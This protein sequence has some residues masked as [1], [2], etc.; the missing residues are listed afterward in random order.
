MLLTL[1]TNEEKNF[2]GFKANYSQ[3]PLTQ[4][5]TFSSGFAF[6]NKVKG[7][8]HVFMMNERMLSTMVSN[9]SSPL[10]QTVEVLSLETKASYPHPS[11]LPIILHKPPVCG[12]SR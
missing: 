4:P 7:R 3:I 5:G 10:V 9:T 1:L 8:Q 11:I 2:P 12:R 6:D